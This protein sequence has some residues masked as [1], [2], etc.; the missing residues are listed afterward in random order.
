MNRRNPLAVISAARTPMAKAFTLL[1]DATAV[2]LGCCAVDSAISRASAMHDHFDKRQI[3][4][5]IIG[6]V[7]GPPD[8]ANVARVIALMSGIDQHRIAHTVNRNCA[9]GMESIIAGWQAI[10]SGRSTVVV[11][12]GTESMSKIPLLYSSEAT[13]R[14]LKL[15]RSKTLIDRLRVLASF[16]NETL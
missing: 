1:S 8:A 9:S 4:E 16:R 13:K 5:V 12:G 3:D 2:E 15:S 14:W 10:E 11:A 6:N 7:A